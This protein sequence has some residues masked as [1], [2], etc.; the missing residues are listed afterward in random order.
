MA[1]LIRKP[2]KRIFEVIL[3]WFL[4]IQSRSYRFDLGHLMVTTPA[5]LV[6]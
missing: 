5:N 4:L 2:A 6:R 1:A 3:C